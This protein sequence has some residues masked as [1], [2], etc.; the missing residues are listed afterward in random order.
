MPSVGDNGESPSGDEKS[1]NITTIQSRTIPPFTF[2]YD[3]PRGLIHAVQALL[4]YTLMLSVMYNLIPV[5]WLHYLIRIGK[6]F[7]PR[8]YHF[9]CGWAWNRRDFLWQNVGI[10][11][12]NR[13]SYL[14][15]YL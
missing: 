7:Q 4:T 15:M 2:A 11:T 13:A 12:S 3:L 14:C 9:H 6:D 10:P 5:D 8:L 1:L